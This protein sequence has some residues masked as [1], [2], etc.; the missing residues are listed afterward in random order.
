MTMQVLKQR[1]LVTYLTNALLGYIKELLFNPDD[2][3][4]D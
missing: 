1:R 4:P 3:A 2:A